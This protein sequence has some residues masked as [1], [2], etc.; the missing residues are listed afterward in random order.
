MKNEIPAS[1]F[2]REFREISESTLTPPGD[3]FWLCSI[4]PTFS[5]NIRIK[6]SRDISGILNIF[7]IIPLFSF[8]QLF[9]LNYTIFHPSFL[10][11][12]FAFNLAQNYLWSVQEKILFTVMPLLKRRTT[13]ARSLL[14]KIQSTIPST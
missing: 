6:P 11:F 8:K 5:I 3:C 10:V 13:W 14:R 7:G 2:S 1:L 4:M 12:F 9:C